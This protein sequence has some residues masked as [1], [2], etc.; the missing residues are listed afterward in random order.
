[1]ESEFKG[2]GLQLRWHELRAFGVR[3]AWWRARYELRKRL[4]MLPR[5]DSLPQDVPKAVLAE[6]T[7]PLG[8][9]HELREYLRGAAK[10]RFFTDADDATELAAVIRQAGWE[11][12]TLAA[13]DEV[14]R[15]RFNLLSRQFDFAGRDIDW[16][17]DPES[18]A[19]WPVVPWNRVDIR[20]DRRLGDVK[21]TWELNRHQFWPTLGRAYRLTADEKYPA[22]WVRQFES[23]CRQNPPEVGVN[24][25]SNLEH[26]LRIISWWWAAKLM[27]GSPHVTGEVLARL[28]GMLIAKARHIVADLDY[29]IVSMANNHVVG[30]A[31][32]LA[33]LG[34]VLPELRQAVE[35]RDMGLRILWREAGRQVLDDGCDF[36]CAAGYHRFVMQFYLLILSLADLNG[37]PVPPDVR[38]RVERMGEFLLAAIRSDGTVAQYGDWDSA[39]AYRLGEQ[40]VTDYRPCLAVAG[41]LFDRGDFR[42]AAGCCQEAIWL[43]GTKAITPS[44]PPPEDSAP[45]G[46]LAFP[47]GGYFIRRDRSGREHLLVKNGPFAAHTHADLLNLCLYSAGRPVLADTGTYTYNGSWRWRTW[48]RS[49]LAHNTVTVDCQGQAL[50]HRVFRWLL[51]PGA[52]NNFFAPG[53]GRFLFD[54]EHTGY[55]RLGVICRRVVLEIHP[56][57]LLCADILTGR[58]EHDIAIRWHLAPDL[59]PGREGGQLVALRADKPALF[60]AAAASVPMDLSIRRGDE[61]TP[62]GWHSAEYGQKQEADEIVFAARAAL[63]FC[64]VTL[65]STAPPVAV[66]CPNLDNDVLKVRLSVDGRP[67]EVT[68]HLCDASKLPT[69][70][71]LELGEVRWDEGLQH[72]VLRARGLGGAVTKPF[73]AI[74]G[75]NDET[76]YPDSVLSAGDGSPA[77][78]AVGTG[79][80]ASGQGSRDHRP[81]SHAELPDGQDF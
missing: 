49:T 3:R 76:T 30:D 25:A 43:A 59:R 19:S 73:Q 45:H 15:H 6:M 21:F 26:A 1:M 80:A 29:S 63:P 11:T 61:E 69:D 81:D 31:A 62:A 51:P 10:G 75:T 36:E 53:Q 14:M 55:R 39:L 56:Q 48:F 44:A 24:W 50:A 66:E 58:G 67:G 28:I 23:W 9:L 37:V 79:Q 74:A 71:E 20:S 47:R 65:L 27:M 40:A 22:E 13:A 33:F 16:C 57:V 72:E 35:W 4:G 12:Q 68:Y 8:D 32:A 41:A 52:R 38:H 60:L 70:K 42:A 2:S 78:Q 64:G 7:V 5:V 54:G 77:S 34:M 46:N 18:G 17:L